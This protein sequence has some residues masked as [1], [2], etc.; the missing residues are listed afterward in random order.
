MI[1]ITFKRNS[2][3]IQIQGFNINNGNFETKK[4]ENDGLM[5]VIRKR[6]KEFSCT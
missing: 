6:T 3:Y 4:I 1:I 5:G 2:S